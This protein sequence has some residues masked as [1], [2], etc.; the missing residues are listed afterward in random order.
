MLTRGGVGASGR[1]WLKWLCTSMSEVGVTGN[2]C[3]GVSGHSEISELTL[4]TSSNRWLRLPSCCCYGHAQDTLRLRRSKGN[5]R[6]GGS[7]IHQGEPLKW[8]LVHA[9]MQMAEAARL[10]LP[11]AYS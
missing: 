10:A 8:K 3:S 6:S 4:S 7:A 1:H 5:M 11:L 2:S 9:A